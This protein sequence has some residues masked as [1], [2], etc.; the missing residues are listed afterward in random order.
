MCIGSRRSLFLRRRPYFTMG[1]RNRTKII[2][3]S[4]LFGV[5][6]NGKTLKD[7]I[8]KVRATQKHGKEEEKEEQ[9]TQI[10]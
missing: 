10:Y 6:E 5:D 9:R 2:Q 3:I 4:D 1:I 7:Y 8:Q